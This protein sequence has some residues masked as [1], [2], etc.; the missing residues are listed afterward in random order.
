MSYIGK[1]SWLIDIRKK[2]RYSQDYVAAMSGM[3][4]SLYCRIERGYVDPGTY[5]EKISQILRFPVQQWESEDKK[6]Q[7]MHNAY[8][9][10]VANASGEK[11]DDIRR[12]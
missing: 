11:Y 8:N 9:G 1:R 12:N 6:M 2:L 4:Q 7:E 5:K 3:S 10:I